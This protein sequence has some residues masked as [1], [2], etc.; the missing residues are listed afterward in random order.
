[1]NVSCPGLLPNY[2]S[3]V[4]L[5]QYKNVSFHIVHNKL[6][7]IWQINPFSFWVSP[8]NIHSKRHWPRPSALF[9][10]PSGKKQLKVT[11]YHFW[12]IFALVGENSYRGSSEYSKN[13]LW[14][15]F[16]VYRVTTLYGPQCHHSTAE[17]TWCVVMP[18]WHK[19][20]RLKIGHETMTVTL[21]YPFYHTNTVMCKNR[22][23]P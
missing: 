5:Q 14:N 10:I 22:G 4:F 13:P 18:F 12:T 11:S 16:E 21:Y 17:A 7:P 8:C 3:I 6:S 23:H 9:L 15:C 2:Y 20:V 1:M 19:H